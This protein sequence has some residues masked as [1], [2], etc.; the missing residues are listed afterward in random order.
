MRTLARTTTIVTIALALVI[1]LTGA[2]FAADPPRTRTWSSPVSSADSKVKLTTAQRSST[3]TVCKSASAQRFFPSQ[4]YYTQN[5][6]W[7][8]TSTEILGTPV[9]AVVVS[10]GP[11]VNFIGNINQ[12]RAW[13]QQPVRYR[14]Y[15]QGHFE[16][17]GLPWTNWYPWVDMTLRPNGA[18]T[19]TT[20]G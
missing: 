14:A 5:V 15:T 16:A 18:W 4:A 10:A 3:A 19:Y 12:T 2:A 7:C 6:E 8:Y 9:A 13:V 11:Q 1:G 17:E 20:G